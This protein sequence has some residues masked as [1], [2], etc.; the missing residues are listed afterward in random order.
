MRERKEEKNRDEVESTRFE[1]HDLHYSKRA[2][3]GRVALR[4]CTQFRIS[5]RDE[6][7]LEERK[8]DIR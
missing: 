7:R 1:L 5:A 2:F 4:L 8:N 6:W 3:G